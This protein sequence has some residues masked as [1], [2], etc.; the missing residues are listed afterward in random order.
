MGAM[1]AAMEAMEASTNKN[2]RLYNKTM[3]RRSV[4]TTRLAY[5]GGVVVLLSAVALM[6]A[7]SS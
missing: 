3:E 6:V 5:L 1:E 4:W 2:V 7:L